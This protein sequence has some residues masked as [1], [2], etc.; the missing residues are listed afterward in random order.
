LHVLRS[1]EA[2]TATA[3][4]QNDRWNLNSLPGTFIHRAEWPINRKPLTVLNPL[5][6]VVFKRLS[7]I[8]E[9]CMWIFFQK[10]IQLVPLQSQSAS[11]K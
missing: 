4:K 10:I 11:I 1:L 7:D 9:L 3:T 6:G 8:D 2:S 5:A